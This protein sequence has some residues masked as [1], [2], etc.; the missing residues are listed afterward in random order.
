MTFDMSQGSSARY[1]VSLYGWNIEDKYLFGSYDSAKLFYE[2]LVIKY[3]SSDTR[4][5]VTISDIITG[6]HRKANA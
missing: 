1:Q 4:V 6:N 2:N 3:R 5:I